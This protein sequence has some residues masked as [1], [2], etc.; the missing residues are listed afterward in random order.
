MDKKVIWTHEVY[1]DLEDIAEFIARD[2]PYYA[3]A[4]IEEVLKVGESLL[5][6]IHGRRDLRTFWERT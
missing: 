5:G 4:F 2:S 6:V 1:N 3:S